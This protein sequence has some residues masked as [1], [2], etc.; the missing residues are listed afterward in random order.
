M[1][2]FKSHICSLVIW[3]YGKQWLRFNLIWSQAHTTLLIGKCPLAKMFKNGFE[4]IMTLQFYDKSSWNV[5]FNFLIGNFLHIIIKC[6]FLKVLLASSSFFRHNYP[7]HLFCGEHHQ[8]N[9][10]FHALNRKSK[11]ETALSR[12]FYNRHCSFL[13]V[14]QAQSW[15][16]LL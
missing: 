4:A 6:I 5:M 12:T 9:K 16:P 13:I 14:C 2:I 15:W 1:K 10:S 7:H 3:L 11:N 8:K